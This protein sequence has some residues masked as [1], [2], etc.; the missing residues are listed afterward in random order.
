M[1]G[2]IPTDQSHN[3]YLYYSVFKVNIELIDIDAR[4]T[5]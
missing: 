5:I 3:M 2:T 4:L 1:R